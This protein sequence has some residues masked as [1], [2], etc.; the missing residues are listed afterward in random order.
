MVEDDID[1]QQ[2]HSGAIE[3]R[4]AECVRPDEIIDYLNW[5][6]APVA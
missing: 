2:T 4:K 6:A 1:R 3:P 5:R